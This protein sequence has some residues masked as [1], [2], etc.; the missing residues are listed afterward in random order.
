MGKSPS[1]RRDSGIHDAA[2]E[3]PL[4]KQRLALRDENNMRWVRHEIAGVKKTLKSLEKIAAEA[5][6]DR[7]DI[8]STLQEL[9][10]KIQ[11]L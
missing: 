8:N 5:R 10:C 1:K 4:K 2:D 7:R 9:L 11:K 3:R 6:E